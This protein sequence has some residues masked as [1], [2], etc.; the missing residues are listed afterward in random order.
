MKEVIVGQVLNQI[1]DGH[2]QGGLAGTV[3]AIN[4]CLVDKSL[5]HNLVIKRIVAGLQIKDEALEAFE[6]FDLYFLK[7]INPSADR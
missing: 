2:S 7:H 5:L 3:G 1:K 4:Q 6:I